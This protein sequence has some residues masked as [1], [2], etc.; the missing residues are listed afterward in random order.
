MEK[1]AWFEVGVGIRTVSPWFSSYNT[2]N[3]ANYKCGVYWY[4]CSQ[5]W[6]AQLENASI[7]LL[8]LLLLLFLTL[9]LFF[10][11]LYT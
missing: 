6:P 11:K 9:L 3:A 5:C 2:G 4:R 8:L 7:V 1:L 10:M